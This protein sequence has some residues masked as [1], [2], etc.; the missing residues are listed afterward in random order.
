MHLGQCPHLLGFIL[1]WTGLQQGK[2]EK[3]FGGC[4]WQDPVEAAWGH[5]AL[6]R[7]LSL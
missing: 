3:G 7:L 6:S 1:V 4:G 5:A 2:G